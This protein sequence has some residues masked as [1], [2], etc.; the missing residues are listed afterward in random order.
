[1]KR[2]ICLMFYISLGL[3]LGSSNSLAQMSG[4]TY[5]SQ[6]IEI[7]SR[8]YV[9][10][11]ALCHGP[12]GGWVDGINLAIGQF[13]TVV[14]DDDLI[15]VISEGIGGGR[16]PAFDLSPADLQ[17]LIAFIRTGF[18]PEGVSVRLGD[19]ASGQKLFEGKGECSECH[20]VNGHGPRTAPDLSDIGLI[21]TP[22][23]LQ[24]SLLDP[25]SALLPINRP[26]TIV[27]RNK[28]TITG[29]RLNEDTYT[30]QLID[31][32]ERLRS[33]A[34]SDLISYEVSETP[35]HEPT[36]LSGD[37]VADLVA[38]LLAQRGLL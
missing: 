21:R 14:T 38:Y 29:R 7:G 17:G 35:T 18:E 19:A 30:V 5:T 1:M 23:A 8:A 27:T 32:K 3:C 16:M 13:R 24:R 36:T 33:L 12:D 31:S 28:E 26:V 20:R 2:K 34:K 9:M 11:C 22:G 25:A 10:Q 6:D 4:H 15:R 37:E